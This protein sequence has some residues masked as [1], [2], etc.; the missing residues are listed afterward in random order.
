ME[1]SEIV[2]YYFRVNISLETFGFKFW[3]I[4]KLFIWK[5]NFDRKLF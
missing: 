5:L 2:F 3:I 1:I 4:N